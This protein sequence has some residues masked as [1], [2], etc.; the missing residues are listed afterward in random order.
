M[1]KSEIQNFQRPQNW[2]SPRPWGSLISNIA[3]HKMFS[4]CDYRGIYI[5]EKWTIPKRKNS[6]WYLPAP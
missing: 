2:V 4:E 5:K 3:E 1:Q 6:L